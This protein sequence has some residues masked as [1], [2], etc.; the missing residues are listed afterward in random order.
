MTP[1]QD[2]LN[3]DY[4]KL[5]NDLIN[6]NERKKAL[7][8]QALRW[9]LT[10]CAPGSLRDKTVEAYVSHDLFNFKNNGNKAQSIIYLLNSENEIVREYIARLLNT[11]A[12]LKKGNSVLLK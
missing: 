1:E 5:K 11:L 9:R 7:I 4:Q 8:L 6:T 12:S 2:I 3:L 10:K